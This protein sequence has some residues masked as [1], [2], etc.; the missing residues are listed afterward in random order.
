LTNI[1]HS[2]TDEEADFFEQQL[3]ILRGCAGH[4]DCTVRSSWEHRPHKLKPRPSDE[5]NSVVEPYEHEQSKRRKSG[6]GTLDLT[7]P[8]SEEDPFGD[9]GDLLLPLSFDD[10]DWS[11]FELPLQHKQERRLR[12]RGNKGRRRHRRFH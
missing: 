11:D 4:K 1:A 9:E 12:G 10:P 2:L 5:L 7:D 8:V 6:P 3:A